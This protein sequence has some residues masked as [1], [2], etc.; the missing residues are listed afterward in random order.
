MEDMYTLTEMYT[1][2][3]QE[4][5]DC[6]N[7]DSA[8]DRQ[9]ELHTHYFLPVKVPFTI[10]TMINFDGIGDCKIACK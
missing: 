3:F 1:D 8:F 5:L 2:S 6:V 9:N 4:K 10:D 7:G